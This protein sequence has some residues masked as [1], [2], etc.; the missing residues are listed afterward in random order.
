MSCVHF[1]KFLMWTLKFGFL[2]RFISKM[3]VFKSEISKHFRTTVSLWLQYHGH[4]ENLIE[5]VPNKTAEI[6]YESPMRKHSWCG[7]YSDTKSVANP[8]KE[9]GHSRNTRW[10]WKSK[11]LGR[12]SLYFTGDKFSKIQWIWQ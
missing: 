6:L 4:R 11:I 10:Q 8:V 1:Y 9:N 12:M 3:L 5:I 7:F 2:K